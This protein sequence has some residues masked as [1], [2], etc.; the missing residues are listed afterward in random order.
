[1][2]A[3]LDALPECE[4]LKELNLSLN[5]VDTQAAIA[6]SRFLSSVACQISKL[7]LSQ[8]DVDDHE[9][10]SFLLSLKS[11][12][13]LTDLCLSGN[14]LGQSEALQVASRA[15]ESSGVRALSELVASAS[16]GL[17]TVDL[18]WNVLR[19]DSAGLFARSLGLNS[20]LTSLNIS[21]NAIGDAAGQL[22]GEALH[23]N[24]SLTF[25]D[26]SN[27]AIMPRGGA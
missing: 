20:S 23:W 26:V 8:A 10:H 16:C 3:I 12:H 13:S 14:L 4:N 5:E 21:F 17:R 25:L 27:N 9:C 19:G 11:N 2:S 7:V 24:D 1:M 18:S 6:L 22:M 15:D